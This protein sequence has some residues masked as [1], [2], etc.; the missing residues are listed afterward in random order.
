MN[1]NNTDEFFS[2]PSF[3][4]ELTKKYFGENLDFCCRLMLSMI[5]TSKIPNVSY[6]DC[7]DMY[8]EY[9]TIAVKTYNPK[10]ASFHFYLKKI[11]E[12]QTYTF[13][14]RVISRQDPL[15]YCSSVDRMLE[16]GVSI[17]E[18]IAGSDNGGLPMTMEL[19]SP[20]L[21][22]VNLTP[23]D[24]IIL[25]YRGCGYSLK[26]IAQKLNT[27]LSTVRRRIVKQRENK[28]LLEGLMKMD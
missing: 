4:L 9:F 24:Q 6:E 18:V 21:K 20:E 8:N 7:E 3:Q 19:S 22:R 23:F 25:Y 11:V 13:I 15:F 1:A 27:S 26:D 5:Q 12:Y 17:H 16:N 28:K 14:R 10:K 2:S